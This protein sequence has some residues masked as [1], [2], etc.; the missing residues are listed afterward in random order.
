MNPNFL[1]IIGYIA[2]AGGIIANIV[3]TKVDEI[4]RNQKIEEEVSKQLSK[5]LEKK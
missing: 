4:S 2:M 5:R 1:K 3:S